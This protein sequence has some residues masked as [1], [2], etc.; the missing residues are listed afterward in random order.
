MSDHNEK[1]LILK[2]LSEGKITAD[3]ASKLLATLNIDD[4]TK[5]KKLAKKSYKNIATIFVQ[6]PKI[7]FIYGII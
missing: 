2:M 4:D 7:F 6:F 1:M 5:K 3:E